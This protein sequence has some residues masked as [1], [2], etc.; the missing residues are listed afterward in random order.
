MAWIGD[1]VRAGVGGILTAAIIFLWKKGKPAFNFIKVILDSG[2]SIEKLND[3]Q[4]E[5]AIEISILKSKQM[6]LLHTSLEPAFITAPNG[7]LIYVNPAWLEMTGFRD[8]KDAYGYGYLK[9]IPVLDR[10]ELLKHVEL[11]IQHPSPSETVIRF[12]QLGTGKIITT[13]CR[14]ELVH[15]GNGVLIETVGRLRIFT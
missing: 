4:H 3:Q 9:C 13:M 7:D 11:L 8:P 12:Q 15:D 10:G 14:T 5:Q 1:S 2:D 6:A